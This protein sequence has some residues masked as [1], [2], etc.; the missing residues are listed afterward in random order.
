MT[1][2]YAQRGQDLGDPLSLLKLAPK[3]YMHL[4]LSKMSELIL[5]IVF[6][7]IKRLLNMKL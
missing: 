6:F 1:L 7:L 5:L 2:G 3:E 4:K